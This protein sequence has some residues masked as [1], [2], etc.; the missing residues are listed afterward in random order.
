MPKIAQYQ[1]D[2]VQT[3]VTAGPKATPLSLSLQPLA[4]GISDIGSGFVEMRN[5]VNTTSAEE[6]LVQ[7]EKA[8][9]DILFNPE[10]G[11]YNTQGKNAYDTAPVAMESLEKLKNEIGDGLNQQSRL[12]FDNV[13]DKHLIRSNADISRHSSKGLKVWEVATIE[14]QVENTIENATLYW[15]NP[16]DLKIQRI[17]GEQAILDSAKLTGIGPEATNEKLQTY[18]SKFMAGA[19]DAATAQSSDEGQKLLD[20]NKGLIEGQDQIKLQKNIDKKKKNE[21]TQFNATQ[22]TLTATRL[23]NDYDSR[24]E[25]QQEV[26]KIEDSELRKKTMSEAMALYSRERQ[27]ESEERADSFEKVEQFIAQGGTAVAYQAQNPEGW[28]KLS[29][30]QQK[31]LT[32]DKPVETNWNTYSG[33]MTMPKETLAKIN[34]VDYFDQLGKTER[35]SLISAV[36]T[37]KG[38]ASKNEG[39]DAQVGRTRAAEVKSAV[40]QIFGPTKDYGKDELKKVNSFYSLVDSEVRYREDVKGSKL[41]SSEFTEVL[42]GFTREAVQNKSS[43][44]WIDVPFTSIAGIPFAQREVEQGIGEI[45]PED[46]PV[47]SDFLR[48]NN[49]PVTGPNLIKAFNQASQPAPVDDQAS[50]PAPVDDV[51]GFFPEINA[52]FG[53]F[54]FNDD[55][56]NKFRLD[57]TPKGKGFFGELERPDGGISTE[58]S[59]GITFNGEPM[60]IPLLVPTLTPG[61]IDLLLTDIPIDDIPKEIIDKAVDHARDRIREGKPPFAQDGEQI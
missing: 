56:E 12:M 23:V 44:F 19:V 41:T 58:L 59:I 52:P 34:P 3:G 26:N 18:R 42:A 28:S 14:S 60:E 20:E 30:A 38:S 29:P 45:P 40:T 35:K 43:F 2:Q 31:K 10:N 7:F 21:E 33:L 50:Q 27:I 13:A 46:I 17:I 11:Y 53:D 9:N 47:L 51:S 32:S 16:K 54:E 49:I 55:V 8:K 5:R 1:P 22:A 57:G 15:N 24:R 48:N 61:E 37:A 4:R 25:I 36:K 39:V 6:A